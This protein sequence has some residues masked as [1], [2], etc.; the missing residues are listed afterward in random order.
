VIAALLG[1]VGLFLLG[2]TLMTDGLKAAA[3]EALRDVLARFTGGALPAFLSGAVLTAMVQSSSATILATIGFVSAGLIG[4]TQ[5]IGVIIGAAVGTTSTGWLVAFLGLKY[6][7]S[8]VAL[9]LIGV[10]ALMRLLSRGRLAAVGLALAGFGLIFVGIDVLQG[11]M[12]VL[13]ERFDVAGLHAET[14]LQRLLLVGIGAAMTV[15][16][17]SS[18]A[19]VATTLA[20]LHAGTIGLDTAAALVIGQNVGTSA[21]AALA[22]IGAVPA[23]RRTALAQI[24][25][26]AF[27]GVVAFLI[28]PLVLPQLHAL[29]DLLAAGEPGAI[30]V[31][32]TAFNVLGAALLLPFAS[33][34][35][36]LVARLVPDRSPPL[37]RNLDPSLHSVAP[38]AVEAARRTVADIAALAISVLRARMERATG[39]AGA[40]PAP[41]AADLAPAIAAVEQTRAF[42]SGVRSSPDAPDEYGRHLTVLHALDHTERLLDALRNPQPDRLIPTDPALQAL[43]GKLAFHL[44]EP[45]YW[46]GRGGG[47]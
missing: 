3:G 36:A 44:Q 25:F 21:T 7:V 43:A 35:A 24:V 15:V 46:G 34:Y 47:S 33:R 19:A 20:A 4:F 8:A 10:G 16:M 9:P 45:L 41:A 37:T 31:F 11:G 2:M 29:T 32:H 5:A 17:Q 12:Q 27:S 38:V 18:S 28:L 22:S 1:G 23:A 13:A 30:A 39:T 42:L 6:S 14:V 26:N 40:E